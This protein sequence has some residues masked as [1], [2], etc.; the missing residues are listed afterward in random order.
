MSRVN[1]KILRNVIDVNHWQHADQAHIA[2]GESNHIFIQLVDKDWSTKSSPEKSGAFVEYP[3]RYISKA[4]AITV[5]AKFLSIDDDQAFEVTATQ[6]FPED[7][8]IYEFSL[9]SSQIPN[10][11]NLVISIDEDGSEKTF[12]IK[13]AIEVDLINAGSC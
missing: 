2:E 11:G 10:A 6:P 8:S 1:A 3:I 13:Q 7:K 12:V 9:S 4:T 5:K